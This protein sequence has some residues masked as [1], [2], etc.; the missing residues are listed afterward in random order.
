MERPLPKVWLNG[1]ILSLREARIRTDDAGVLFGWG[2]FETIRAYDG[3]LFD[4][5]AHLRRLRTTARML[6][7]RLP[8]NPRR[9]LL[10]A[11]RVLRANRRRDNV[12][13][14]LTLT[15]GAHGDRPM[16]WIHARDLP[17]DLDTVR[18]R[19][20]PVVTVPWRRN[21]SGPFRGHKTL[22]YLEHLWAR[23]YARRREAREALYLDPR[24]RILEGSASSLFVVRRGRVATP[25]LS[26]G[27][28]PGITRARV[29]RLASKRGLSVRE[30][31]IP[32]PELLDAD[33]AFLTSSGSE[34]LP[35]R[36]VDG[37][38]LPRR[39]GIWRILWEDYRRAVRRQRPLRGR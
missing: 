34:I 23:E 39:S 1:R 35:I 10:A 11:Q 19:G 32:F 38:P 31:T 26:Q 24:G 9:I 8:L 29:L 28:L 2:A 6:S 20:V 4:A 30:R 16:L 25:P 21:P 12:V 14:R 5:H 18:T 37:R 17:P 13:L 27:I 22:Q 15:R 3:V 33:E 7:I 36:S